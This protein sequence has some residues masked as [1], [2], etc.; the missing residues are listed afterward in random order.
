MAKYPTKGE[1][2]ATNPGYDS[3]LI[4]CIQEWT[5]LIKGW[6]DIDDAKK[7][8]SL[9]FLIYIIC[10]FYKKEMPKIKWEKVCK[11]NSRTRTMYLDVTNPSIVSTLH[12]LG[13]HLHGA[14]ELK[15]CQWSIHLFKT[16]FPASYKKL[17]WKGHLLV[18]E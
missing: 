1:I 10:R 15:A 17:K 13:H 5:N 3:H 8:L 7:M 18:K 4:W 12:E 9:E 2:L 16:I 14:S 6:K 11:Y